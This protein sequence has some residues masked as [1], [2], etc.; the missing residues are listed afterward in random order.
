M[1]TVFFYLNPA[2]N[3]YTVRSINYGTTIIFFGLHMEFEM[4]HSKC[5]RSQDLSFN[6]RGSIYFKKAWH[7]S[8]FHRHTHFKG[9]Q[10]LEQ[11]NI[12]ANI[13]VASKT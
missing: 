13:R 6:L 11:T 9:S 10:I 4:K 5:E 1:V 7:Y 12:S 8:H 2:G 3:I